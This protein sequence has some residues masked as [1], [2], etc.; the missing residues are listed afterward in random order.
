MVLR[1][2]GRILRRTRLSAYRL[3]GT[4]RRSRRPNRRE[5]VALVFSVLLQGTSRQESSRIMN[6]LDC[7]GDAKSMSR[8][9]SGMMK[10]GVGG[11][12][13]ATAALG[14]LTYTALMPG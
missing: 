13:K 10:R 2:S 9:C 5:T 12:A 6:K 8:L 7:P 4:L 14:T 1:I 11:T 3:V